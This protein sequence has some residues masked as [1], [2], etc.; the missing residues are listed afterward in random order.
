MP[1]GTYTKHRAETKIA[2]NKCIVIEIV[3][4]AIVTACWVY[5]FSVDNNRIGN[6]NLFLWN[7]LQEID[8]CIE[9]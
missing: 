8:V 9:Q 7:T 1:N 4:I 5:L 6:V 3:V 2:L